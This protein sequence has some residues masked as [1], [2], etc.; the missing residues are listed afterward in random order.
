MVIILFSTTFII[1]LTPF[2]INGSG[3]GTGDY[4]PP[5]QGDWIITSDTYVKNENITI[6][7]NITI[8][9]G[10]ELTLDNV[11]LIINA[12][13]YGS[14]RIDVKNGGEFNVI[15]N[16]IIMEGETK[17]NYDFMFEYGSRGL[18][19]ESTIRDCGW[20]DGGTWQSTGG[21]LIMSDDVIIENSTIQYNYNGVVVISSSPIIRFNSIRDHLNYGIFLLNASTQIT[22][23]YIAFNPVG[24]NCLYSESWLSENEILDNGDGGRFFYSNI[25]LNGDRISSNDRNDCSTG[26]CSSAESGKGLLAEDTNISMSNV[27]ISSNSDDGLI[28]YHSNIDV[29]NSTFSDNLG[30][31]IIG[32]YSEANLMNNIFGNNQNYGIQWMYTSLELDETNTFPE[33]NGIGRIILEWDVI[34]D[35]M[36]S[37]G[38]MVSQATV[39]FEGNDISYSMDSISGIA[40]MSVAE[41]EIDNN[42]LLIGYNPYNITAKKIALWDGIEY[43]NSTIMEIRDNT[44]M[45]ISIPLKKPDLKVDSISFSE[46]PKIGKEVKIKIKISNIGDAA[47]NNV[48]IIVTQ[49]DSLGKTTV[50]NKTTAS[51]NLDDETELSV[52]WIPE[53]EG[54]ASVKAVVDNTKNIN[55][56][57]EDNNELV[58]TVKV[59]EK[60]VPIYEE[61]YFLAGLVSFL[62]ILVGVSIYIIILGKKTSKE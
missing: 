45:N 4:P 31:G 21:I 46:T 15:N 28:A 53:Q 61:P 54:D 52:A 56:L 8:E 38:D 48:S 58:T 25:Y 23:N 17:V 34:V 19:Q 12:S 22:G 29:Q 11:T 9:Y 16:S 62:I 3:E 60:D 14:A 35:V 1:S 44:M 18:I 42:G 10:A 36:D 55:E 33:N 24:I 2:S 40:K 7:G 27:E 5:S 57:D 26:A 47:A 50:V 59:Q 51:V 41:Y 13:D 30:N 43:S 49:K 6:E 20:N 32:Y 39:E 37:Y